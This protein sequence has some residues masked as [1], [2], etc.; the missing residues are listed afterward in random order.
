VKLLSAALLVS[1]LPA[2]AAEFDVNGRH[3]TLPDGFTI[4]LAA[5][6]DIAP[7][8]ISGSFDDKGRLY[9]TDSSGSN[10]APSK[11]AEHPTHRV[12]QLTDA[13]GDGR[14][15]KATVFAEKLMFPEGCLWLNGSLYVGA[16]P[17]ILKFSDTN[18]DGV[19]DVKTTWWDGGTL[20]GC[21][22][23]L[24]GPYAGPDGFIYW[25]KG[26]FAEQNH[27]RPGRAPIHDKAAH[28]FRMRPDGADFEAV[29]TGGMDNPVEVAFTP[30][31]EALFTST[32]IDFSQPGRRDG[33]AYAVYGG[34]YGKPNHVIED[35]RVTRT[36]P[37]LL[38]VMTQFGAGA[39]SGLCRKE[40]AAWGEAYRDNFFASCFNLHKIT[41]HR[42]TFD[43]AG[44]ASTNEDFLVSTDIDFHPTDVLE[45]AD[46]SLVVVDTGGWYRLCCPSSQL[47]KPDVLGGVYRIRK[48]G[49]T[50]PK[51]APGG[52][53][54]HREGPYWTAKQAGLNRDKGAAPNLRKTLASIQNGG[55]PDHLELARVVCEALGRIGNAAD[56]PAILAAATLSDDVY[57]QHSVIYALYEINVVEPVRAGLNSHNAAIRRA[58][59]L[60]L[61]EMPAGDLKPAEV[62]ARLGDPSPAVASAAQYILGR[63][64]E[65]GA[66]LAGWF[67][68][69]WTSEALGDND[70]KRESLNR[71]ASI[72]VD[73]SDG[74]ALLGE[75]V[76]DAKVYGSTRR[77]AFHAIAEA[78]FKT[79]P[80]IW[81]KGVVAAFKAGLAHGEEAT[82][83]A[84]VRAAEALGAA[85]DASAAL[86][87][88]AADAGAS[89]AVRTAALAGLPAGQTLS[90]AEFDFLAAKL[91]GSTAGTERA[92]AAAALAKADLSHDQREGLI[93]SLGS[94]DPLTLDRLLSAFDKG[95]DGPMA[96]RL[97]A[98]LKTAPAGKS[99]SPAQLRNH[100]GQYP[101][102]ARKT[103]EGFA[104]TLDAAAAAQGAQ[105]TALLAELK[106]IPADQRRGQQIFNGAKAACS[107]C[108]RIGY[109]GGEI[110]PE[111]T[112]IGEVRSEQDLLESIAFPNASFARGYEPTLLRMKD[113][114]T[115]SGI[116]Q[117]E[118]G[119]TYEVVTGPG[120]TTVVKRA[121]VAEKTPGSVSIMPSGFAE[122][123][124]K[125]ELADL[126]HFV[127]TV[128]WR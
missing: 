53:P 26:A 25:T 86:H 106:K 11:Q 94:A 76:A 30:D 64:Q 55:K 47:A 36:S 1:A 90:K 28:I 38:P 13:D 56:A 43:G 127:K 85:K 58:A 120:P 8:P 88:A 99:L 4:E 5:G 91:G 74:K 78:S 6:P 2:V 40:S 71:T 17:V 113:G 10:E 123:L 79:P 112:T 45:D 118:T 52:A 107:A 110:G 54:G 33:I 70:P 122:A 101:E 48:T 100:Y 119:E 105:L 18:Q 104:L 49:A 103:M 81:V 57:L 63:R 32:F 42:F 46:G 20:T 126:L 50:G 61:A 16:P 73:S 83:T 60:A 51:L 128:R 59:L 14:F 77:A 39:P 15:D 108:H 98:A 22:N 69:Q 102:D 65:W 95:V 44:F 84:G 21:A 111:L 89:S 34:V 75:I 41:R 35:R 67:R 96:E 23:D 117:H 9:V 72:L 37:D 27:P 97:V 92:S 68:D 12:L 29:M 24:H 7:R 80:E 124:T 66:P 109:I 31:G 87:A 121:D 114:E 62:A 19:A 93:A 115:V 3:F 82:A 116:I 125:Q